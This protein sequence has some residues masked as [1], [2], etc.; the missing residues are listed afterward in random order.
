MKTSLAPTSI[1]AALPRR[2][3]Q[4]PSDLLQ[5]ARPRLATL[6]LAVIALAYVAAQPGSGTGSG[7]F[8]F[9][10]FGLLLFGSTLAL[11]GASALN[12]VIERDLDSLMR[13]TEGRP[14]PS[15]RVSPVAAAVYGALL[16]GLGLAMLIPVGGLTAALAA[17][18]LAAYL[19]VYTPLK[20]LTATSTLVGAVPGAVPALMGWTAV[21][22][23]VDLRGLSLF[24]I[25]LL[26]QIP[27]F[28]A[29]AWMYRSDY[30]RAGFVTLADS[31]PSGGTTAR[32]VLVACAA[33]APV[34]AA[35]SFVGLTGGIYFVCAM[36]LAA[37]FMIAAMRFNA[38]RSGQ[39]AR[40]LL[41]ASVLYLPALLI[42]LVL[43]VLVTR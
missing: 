33:L 6:G 32:Y 35:P 12:Q 23:S 36:A 38:Q 11:C 10:R 18:G 9:A 40:S 3:T 19:L 2:S 28:L 42:V 13:R 7:S 20:R 24:A 14:L 27:H 31:D 34:S 41:R 21:T 15:G 43:D 16:S 25:L 37:Y 5:L 1:G 39:A 30:A 17:G 26:W 4:L 22:G 8:G 29:I